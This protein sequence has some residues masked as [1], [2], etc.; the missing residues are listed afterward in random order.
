MCGRWC[1]GFFAGLGVGCW[2]G[3][4]V[5]FC[6]CFFV[7]YVLLSVCLFNSLL[8]VDFGFLFVLFCCVLFDVF[9]FSV[10]LVFEFVVF[11]FFEAVLCFFLDCPLS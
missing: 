10:L 8:L 3:W 2:P 7:L 6:F 5:V 4:C 1:F 11:W 9:G